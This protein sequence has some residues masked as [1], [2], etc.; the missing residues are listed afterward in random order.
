MK[1][2]QVNALK[3]TVGALLAIAI[4]LGGVLQ[5]FTLSHAQ[6]LAKIVRQE[7]VYIQANKVA[8]LLSDAGSGMGGYTMTRMPLYAE[9]FN[10]ANEVLPKAMEDL[11][12]LG[13]FDGPEAEAVSQLKQCTS[14][15]MALLAQAQTAFANPDGMQGQGGGQRHKFFG[16]YKSMKEYG[17][18]IQGCVLRLAPSGG[19]SGFLQQKT[20]MENEAAGLRMLTV[21]WLVASLLLTA[22]LIFVIKQ[23]PKS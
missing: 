8:Q 7:I 4:V 21:V 23:K 19:T 17:E 22:A 1:D 20:E 9:K 2:R 15:S 14:E 16:L 5:T 18:R 11:G 13:P 6:K 3:L 12:E 10:K